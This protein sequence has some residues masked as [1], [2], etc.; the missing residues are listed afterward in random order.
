MRQRLEPPT[1][2]AS[3]P[4][5]ATGASGPVNTGPPAGGA[6]RVLPNDAAIP[7]AAPPGSAGYGPAAPP[8]GVPPRADEMRFD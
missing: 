8:P 3:G 4:G 1:A 2:P 7:G 5:P 6:V